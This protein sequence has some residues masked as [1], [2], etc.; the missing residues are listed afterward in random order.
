[1]KLTVNGK[2]ILENFLFGIAGI[3]GIITKERWTNKTGS[4]KG[5]IKTQATY[6]FVEGICN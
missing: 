6:Q 2:K 3:T 4:Y 5:Q 1:M